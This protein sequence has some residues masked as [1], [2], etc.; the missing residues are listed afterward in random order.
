MG[1][2][3]TWSGCFPQERKKSLLCLRTEHTGRKDRILVLD[4]GTSCRRIKKRNP[5]NKSRYGYFLAPYAYIF[6]WR[7]SIKTGWLQRRAGFLYHVQL[8]AAGRK[9]KGCTEFAQ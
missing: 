6:C 7:Q 4:P 2:R 5:G 8:S 1:T 9:C 3:R